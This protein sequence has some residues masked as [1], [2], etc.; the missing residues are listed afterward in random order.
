MLDH[1]IEGVLTNSFIDYSS[2]MPRIHYAKNLFGAL[3][4]SRSNNWCLMWDGYQINKLNH[5]I[6]YFSLL[7]SGVLFFILSDPFCCDPNIIFTNHFNI[8]RNEN[9]VNGLYST[10]HPKQILFGLVCVNL[11][12]SWSTYVS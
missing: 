6:C 2:I 9:V 8:R 11:Q 1:E 12:T 3:K 10:N 5:N 7:F 4:F